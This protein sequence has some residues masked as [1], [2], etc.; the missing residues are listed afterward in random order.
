LPSP[1][2]ERIGFHAVYVEAPGGT[3]ISPSGNAIVGSYLSTLGLPEAAILNLTSAAPNDMHWLTPTEALRFGIDVIV[4]D[5]GASSAPQAESGNSTLGKTPE[6][7]P[8]DLLEQQASEFIKRYVSFENE[9]RNRSL[10]LVSTAY[11]QQVLHFGKLKTKQEV[12]ADY[13]SFTER[14]PSR[15]YS[16][17]PGL[18]VKCADQSR[19]VA[20]GLLEWDAASAERN[21]KSTGI[22]SLHIELGR[23]AGTFAIVAIDGKVLHHRL[24]KLNPDR[25]F[26]LGPL[27]IGGTNDGASN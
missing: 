1:L 16:L 17:K 23:E 6:A 19:C 22:T 21:A 26:C 8:A 24:D 13:A 18:V 15:N 14:W 2:I 12:L 9:E 11:A 5:G 10:E 25:R 27:C 4:R 7:T 20:D 3:E